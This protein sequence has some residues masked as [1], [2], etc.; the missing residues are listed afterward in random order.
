VSFGHPDGQLVGQLQQRSLQILQSRIGSLARNQHQV[1]SGGQIV[2]LKPERLAEQAFQSTPVDSVAVFPR[3][4][5]SESRPSL[6]ISDIGVDQQLPIAG[7]TTS[8]I[9]P[10]E[11]PLMAEATPG[12]KTAVDRRN[13]H[14]VNP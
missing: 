3:N 6:L 13:G 9:D 4:T 2:L 12:R 5:Q 10:F 8:G 11:V 1:E 14:W 7:P